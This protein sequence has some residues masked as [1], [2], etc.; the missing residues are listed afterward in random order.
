DVKRV[1]Y[2]DYPQDP[3]FLGKAHVVNFVMQNYAYG[4]YVKAYANEFLISN[5]GQLNLFSKFQYRRMTYDLAVGGWYSDNDHLSQATVETYRLPQPDGTV[6]TF[7]RV[8][9]PAEA[10]VRNRS[11]WPTFKAAFNTD[12]VTMVNT[13]GANFYFAPKENSAGRV[14]F[15]PAEFS[16]TEYES[17]NR[18]HINSITYSGYW[19]FT[20]PHGNSINLNPYYS[21]SH[22]RQHS[23]Y[24]EASGASLPNGAIDDSHRATTSARYIH[25]FGRWGN[26]TALCNM[27]YEAHRTHYSGTSHA[28]DRLIT[29]RI[30]PG[31]LY[32]YSNEHFNG[33]IG[34]GF[35][36]DRS[37]FGGKAEHSTQPWVDLSLQYSIS[38]KHSAGLEFHHSAWAPASSFRST[39]VI[40]SNPL[41]SYTGNPDLKPEK[42]YD[43]GLRYVGMP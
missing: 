36:Y 27:Y 7:E 33:L 34:G 8:S 42:S 24:T 26:V 16:A 6:K 19:N 20:L 18:S 37:R 31:L 15:L 11:L 29:F 23:L 28:A 25:D 30:G 38:D 9:E 32:N 41:L 2:Y 43:L 40:Q 22:T 39:A 13:V 21:Y 17:L 14:Y 3:R 1:E 10:C 4:G 5:S 12:K 35:N